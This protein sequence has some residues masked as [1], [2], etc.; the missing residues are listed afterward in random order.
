MKKILKYIMAFLFWSGSLQA[1]SL[2][3]EIDNTEIP[4]GE[5]FNLN[6]TYDGADGG[7]LQPDLS[8]LQQDFSI[9]S[10]SNSSQVSIING[11]T[12]RR[13]DWDIGLIAK[14]EGKIT[15][16]EISVGKNKSQPLSVNILPAGTN[17]LLHKKGRNTNVKNDNTLAESAKFS[18]DLTVDKTQAYMQQ[19][20][21]AEV[22]I[23]EKLG[24]QLTSEPQ[25]GTTTDWIIKPLGNP[26][27]LQQNNEREIRFQYA[28]FPQK[29]GLLSIPSV[30]INGF[31][32]SS[33]MVR[34]APVLQQGFNSL[35]Q[36][37]SMDFDDMFGVKKPVELYTKPVEI[38]ILPIVSEW[39]NDWWIPAESLKLQAFWE[40][41]KPLFKIGETIAREIVITASGVDETQ[42][43]ELDFSS[44]E[45]FKQYPENPQ[46]TSEIHNGKIVSQS[47]IRVVYI[48]QKGGEQILPEIKLPWFN[49]KTKKIEI[50]NIPAEKIF[51]EGAIQELEKQTPETSSKE[52]TTPEKTEEASLKQKT[53][54]VETFSLKM[55]IFYLVG[56]F[57]MGLL[58]SRVLQNKSMYKKSESKKNNSAWC[59]IISKD[60]ELKD[61]RALRDDLLKWGNEEFCE[62]QICNLN[63]LSENVDEDEFRRQLHL[64]NQSLYG[65]KNME[66]DA[67]TILKIVKSCH[68]SKKSKTAQEPLPKLYK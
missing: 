56:A 58:F 35:F 27:I 67:K 64:L 34:K 32:V 30:K 16:P 68:L 31:Y 40:Q 1:Q 44:N 24:L 59:K 25:F 20:I 37:M 48:P 2:V 9:Y 10:T 50:A 63:D 13:Y 36:M 57:V 3:A 39:K 11:Q 7:S 41:K 60:L 26:K 62:A 46:L 29:N 54:K 61:Y 66:L 28:L 15:I 51:V 53:E 17:V 21:N 52:T 22:V 47:V 6:L 45:S 4:L 12:F 49:V 19:E 33:E 18:V 43:P 5:V 65:D 23:R 8:A 55:M 38:K 14:H 42:L